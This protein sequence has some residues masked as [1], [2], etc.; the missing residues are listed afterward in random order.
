MK[1]PVGTLSRKETTMPAQTE[2]TATVAATTMVPLK[3]FAVRKD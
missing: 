1:A 3:L 2:R